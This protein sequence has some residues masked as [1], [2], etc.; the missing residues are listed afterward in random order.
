MST[1]TRGTFADYY[2][3]VSTHEWMHLFTPDV[4]EFVKSIKV[5]AS[6]YGLCDNC[7]RANG[8]YRSETPLRINQNMCLACSRTAMRW[9]SSDLQAVFEEIYSAY[10]DH[11]SNKTN[12][13]V[14]PADAFPTQDTHRGTC[15]SCD[16]LILATTDYRAHNA[17]LSDVVEAVDAQGE[18][19]QA[20]KHCAFRCMTCLTSKLG[21][22]TYLDGAVICFPCCDDE[23][24]NGDYSQ[25]ENCSEWFSECHYSDA[26]DLSLCTTCYDEGWDCSECYQTINE[27]EFHECYRHGFIYDYSYKPK[28]EFYGHADYHFGFELEVEDNAGR[29]T[30]QGAE[31]VLDALGDRVYCKHDGSLDDGFEIVSHPHSFEQLENLDWNFLNQLRNRGYRSW[32]TN[33]CGLHVHISRT[34]FEKNGKR[35][36]GHELRFQKLI[37][38]NSR[39]VEAIAG[40]S[41]SYARFKDKGYLVPKIKNGQQADR[42]EAVNSFNDATLEV[43]VFRGSLRKQ[44]ILSAIEFLHAATEYTRNMRINPKDKQL[45]WYRFMAY[46]LDNQDKYANFTQ[47]A[48]KALETTSVGQFNSTD[49]DN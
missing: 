5:S 12:D 45:S 26:R 32:D 21:N 7:G 40:R 4:Y 41:S 13:L 33:T 18:P 35:D 2:E 1:D 3:S 39:M 27:G 47:V 34:A 10:T 19:V 30:Q 49:E 37:Y 25:C 38:D 36:E 46:V 9:G 16:R 42:Y 6:G 31:L 15:P 24:E 44:R 20:H 17:Y 43:R 48:L 23:I 29:G 8:L 22:H 28:P 14:F 11:N